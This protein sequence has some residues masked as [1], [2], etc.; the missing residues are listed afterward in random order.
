VKSIYKYYLL[1]FTASLILGIILIPVLVRQTTTMSSQRLYQKLNFTEIVNGSCAIIKGDVVDISLAKWAN[2]YTSKDGKKNVICRDVTI[3]IDE[4]Y[5]QLPENPSYVVL[6]IIC[7][8][9]G[10]DSMSNTNQNNIKKEKVLVF[11]SAPYRDSETNDIVY[12]LSRGSYSYHSIEN[13]K[14]QTIEIEP[15]VYINLDSLKQDIDLII[16][17]SE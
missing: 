12:Q 7:G 13:S 5:K 1:V 9:I 14:I 10:N 15:D 2:N 16:Q 11:L 6:R 3:K 17:D 4:Y 8:T